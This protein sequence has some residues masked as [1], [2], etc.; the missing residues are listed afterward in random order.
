LTS[1]ITQSSLYNKDIA[2]T[3]EAERTWSGRSIFTMWM[4]NIH[5]IGGYT[6]AAG[7]FFTGLVGWQVLLALILGIF[8]VMI[9]VN[10]TGIAGQRTGVPFAVLARASLGVYGANIAGLTRAIVA[11][12]WYGIQTYLASAAVVVLVTAIFPGLRPL[13]AGG[14]LGLSALGWAAFLLLWVLQLIVLLNGMETVRKYQDWAGPAIWIVMLV[15]A[16]WIIG[17]AHGH[18]GLNVASHRVTGATA[19]LKFFSAISL[20]V[21]YLATLMLNFSDF[22]RFSP[23]RSDVIRGN[24]LGL[25]VNFTAFAL[26]SVL[27]TTGTVTVYGKAITDP[28]ELVSRIHNTAALIIGAATFIIATIGVNIV[29]NFVSPAFDL[30]NL[31]PRYINWRRGG[32]ISAVIALAVLPWKLYSTPAIIDYFLGALGAF[33]GPLFAILVVD[34]YLLRRQRISI[35]DLYSTDRGGRYY[36]RRGF[37]PSALIA[38]IPSTILAVAVALVPSFGPAAPF[39]WF[40]GAGLAGII[41]A[42]LTLR[43]PSP[44]L[45]QA[46]A[47]GPEMA[48]SAAASS[49]DASGLDEGEESADAGNYR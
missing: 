26:V 20:T 38:F 18:V 11:I 9:G 27:V 23:K 31:A 16:I 37:N 12:L 45:R 28:V 7:L 36:Y 24:F 44:A 39:S 5:N 13:A 40:V 42:V 17:A 15:L 49:Q 2:P 43:P 29:A 1:D 30:A 32:A 19:F 25:P 10:L 22:S 47:P 4:S 46:P 21:A 14:F 33:L 48:A 8:I 3:S 41:Y 34:Y 6:F 35:S